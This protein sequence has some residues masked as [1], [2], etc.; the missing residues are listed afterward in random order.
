MINDAS[1]T[2]LMIDRETE[3]WGCCWCWWCWW[4]WCWFS[5][6]FVFELKF[7][8][9]SMKLVGG[10]EVVLLECSVL[11][12]CFEFLD[13]CI[14][15][16]DECIVFIDE[17]LECND[18]NEETLDNV[19]DVLSISLYILV[20]DVLLWL[21]KYSEGIFCKEEVCDELDIVS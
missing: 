18:E 14:V 10:E 19:V 4:C 8:F 11:I 3:T 13:V 5:D 2:G 17:F 21:L 16:L 1:L 7:V 15:F 9:V 20:F 6:K 12:E